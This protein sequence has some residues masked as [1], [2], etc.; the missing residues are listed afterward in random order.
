MP[1]PEGFATRRR[2]ALFDDLV[3]LM[4][5][6]GFAHLSVADIA[7]RLRCS[8]STLYTLA[9]SKEQLAT[10]AVTHFFKRATREVED[11][12]AASTDVRERVVI[13]LLAVGEALSVASDQFMRDLDDFGPTHALYERNTVAASARVAELISAGADAGVF[14]SVDAGFAADL[15]ATMMRRIQRREVRDAT[16]LDDATAYRQL[17]SI[18]FAG[19]DAGNASPALP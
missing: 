1:A 15:T 8:K 12:V 16:G 5:A 9:D 2:A 7:Q 4:L 11:R 18:L 17:A 10:A 19:I 13:Y 3:T 6:E 14:R